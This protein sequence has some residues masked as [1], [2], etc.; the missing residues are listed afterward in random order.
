MRP[1]PLGAGAD[2][3][4]GTDSVG[5]GSDSGFGSTLI[6]GLIKSSFLDLNR[7]NNIRLL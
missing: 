3:S 5:V 6:G 2:S 4:V 1:E 7:L